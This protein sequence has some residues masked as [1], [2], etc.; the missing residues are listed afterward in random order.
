MDICNIK[1]LTMQYL[2]SSSISSFTEMYMLVGPF[3]NVQLNSFSLYHKT[4]RHILHDILLKETGTDR[5]LL[6]EIERISLKM[7]TLLSIQTCFSSGIF[8]YYL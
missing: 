8:S 3:N 6:V 2:K 7:K 5:V 1:K 4:W